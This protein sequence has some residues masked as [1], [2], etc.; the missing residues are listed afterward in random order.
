MPDFEALASWARAQTASRG[1]PAEQIAD[2]Q[3]RALIR[4]TRSRRSTR[5]LAR[6]E[7]IRVLELLPAEFTLEGGELTPTLKVK[8][9]VINTKY[10]EILDR[11]YAGTE[12]GGA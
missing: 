8:R 2:P 9:R 10:G 6:Y 11:L 5:D 7:Q 1:G 3:V 12:A 4:S